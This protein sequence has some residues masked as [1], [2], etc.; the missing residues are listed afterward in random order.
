MLRIIPRNTFI[1]FNMR[2]TDQKY[3]NFLVNPKWSL[4]SMKKQIVIKCKKITGGCRFGENAC[5]F[6]HGPVL[7][8]LDRP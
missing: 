7:R 5:P 6:E 4:V 1:L 2:T 3:F 8:G